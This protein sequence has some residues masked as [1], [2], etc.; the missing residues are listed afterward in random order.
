LPDKGDRVHDHQL[1]F[2][3]RVRVRA[4]RAAVARN[5]EA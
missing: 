4:R 2:Q 3:R 5:R 1:N